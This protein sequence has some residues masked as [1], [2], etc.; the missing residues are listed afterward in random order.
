[1][2]NYHIEY[3]MDGVTHSENI[4]A[5]TPGQAQ[6]KVMQLYP[7]AKVTRCIWSGHLAGKPNMPQVHIEYESVSTA[8]VIPLGNNPAME[9][10]SF[11]FLSKIKPGKRR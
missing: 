1:M 10:T 4:E 6:G 3:E 9:Q 8:R 5:S 11:G 7:S 2:K